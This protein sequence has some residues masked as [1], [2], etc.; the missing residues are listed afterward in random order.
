MAMYDDARV[1]LW[2]SVIGAVSW[3][4][5]GDVG[6]FQYAP[7]FLQS[8]IQVA[9]FMM[10]LDEFP[11]EFSALARNT[12]KG[13]PGL[14]ADSLPDRFGDTVID[15]WLMSQG[16]EPS[17]IHAVQRLCFIG[18]R[19]MGALEFEP[20]I[21][22]TLAGSK[23]VDIARL[24]A[25]TNLILEERRAPQRVFRRHDTR[26][27][28]D[29]LFCVAAS[30][31]GRRAKAL[32]AWNPVTDEFRSGP[33]DVGA[34]FEDW[35]IKF[36]GVTSSLDRETSDPA[37]SGSIEYAFHLMAV[38]AGIVMMPCRLHQ[39]GG[40]SHFMTKRFDRTANGGK[41]HMQSL[42]AMTH[43]DYH[44]PLS[45]S[46][47]QAIQLMRRL[48]LKREDLEQLVLRAMFNVI[49]CNHD[50]HVNNSAF[51]MNRR[52][53]WRLSPAFDLSYTSDPR[54]VW[55]MLHRMSINGKCEDFKREDLIAL[56]SVAGIKK[57]RA[58]EMIYRV[59]ETVRRW[60][61]FAEKAGVTEKRMAH[62]QADQDTLL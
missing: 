61:Y 15:A 43:I 52:G 11:Y 5:E 28:I 45:Y 18:S 19:A 46:Y 30:A 20:V 50:D 26:E 57:T 48:G 17:E 25:A 37:G 21:P 40:R 27:M 42:G 1:R 33:A 44:Q 24:V 8:G 12:F 7:Q 35:M 22:G 59:T 36:D 39:E 41:Y 16:Y 54:R 49:A 58:N 55:T 2:G 62:I 10:P 56:A 34:G 14:L 6:V 23:R 29:A 60:P 4:D 31:G 51:L 38:E 32:L 9:P 53:Q 3:L 47:E 13:L